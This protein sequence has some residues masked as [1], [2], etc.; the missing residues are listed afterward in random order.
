MQRS[1]RVVPIPIP[2]PERRVARCLDLDEPDVGPEGVAGAARQVDAV[3]GRDRE[4]D[5]QVE[6]PVLPAD[7]GSEGVRV[8]TGSKPSVD[9]GAGGGLENEPRLGL[10]RGVRM[11]LDVSRSRVDLHGEVLR[12]VENLDEH[13]ETSG[14]RRRGGSQQRVR[15]RFE[16]LVER[17]T[18]HRPFLHD[19]PTIGDRGREVG[20]GPR[21]A[22]H[23]ALVAPARRAGES[24]AAPGA[25]FQNRFE[26]KRGK[27]HAGNG[28]LR[29]VPA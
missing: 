22:D 18:G 21:F 8:H 13:R 7:R 24:V 26:S 12:G 28:I 29:E 6:H 20:E 4:G 23:V 14:I 16:D 11:V 15:R 2:H 27:T 1:T 9:D 19:G 25:G 10:H 17:A 3:A 5:E